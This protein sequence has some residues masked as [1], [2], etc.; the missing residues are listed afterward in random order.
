MLVGSGS[1]SSRVEIVVVEFSLRELDSK[2][3]SLNG[4]GSAQES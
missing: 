3:D 4:H 2:A 1:L